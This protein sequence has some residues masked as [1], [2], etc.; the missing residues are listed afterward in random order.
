MSSFATKAA[1]LSALA[2]TVLGHGT[3]TGIT[4]DGVF[5]QGFLLDYY[6][7]ID[8]NRVPPTH[9]GWYAENLDNGFIDGTG[10]K[11][12][13]INCH[14][15]A[16]P[17]TASATVSAGG[18]IA[19]H[20]TAW[21]DSHKGPILT[22]V[23]PCNGDCS[24]VDKTALQWIKIDEAAIDLTTQ[25][26]PTAAMIAN[27]NTYTMTVPSGLASGNYVLRHEII[28][29]H[30]ALGTNGAQNYP[31]CFNIEI[32]GG[33]S[34]SPA[35]TLGTE[36]YSPT[37]AGILFDPYSTLTSY[38]IPGPAL[39]SGGSSGGSNPAPVPTAAPSATQAPTSSAPA[40][41]TPAEEEDEE[42]E[43]DDE[44]PCTGEEGG[45]EEVDDDEE[46]DEEPCTG[47][48]EED[49]EE[50]LPTTPAPIVTAAPTTLQTSTRPATT[51][52]STGGSGNAVAV[53]GQCGGVSY[54]GSTT[55][56]SGSTCVVQNPYYSQCIP[57]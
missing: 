6:Y 47:D 25:E 54:T 17:A 32:T 5:N 48:D 13:D 30:G 31:Q 4:T 52:P 10:Y 15:N 20:W 53:Y 49:D 22:Y 50:P 34:D 14:K 56:A 9:V 23:A 28:A 36:L 37:D 40:P 8:Q 3:V 12:A 45:S 2:G 55:C 26:W 27:N 19:F 24:T 29:M 51:A 44:E 43:E 18:T 7:M 33:G 41:T 46:D 38:E 21:P 42:E 1:L 57:K 16:A 39:Y 35:G 11:S